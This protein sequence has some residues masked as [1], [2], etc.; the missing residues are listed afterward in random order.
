MIRDKEFFKQ[1]FEVKYST[2]LNG[3]PLFIDGCK[4]NVHAEEIVFFENQDYSK[5]FWVISTQVDTKE[6]G[7]VWPQ[8][9]SVEK[10]FEEEGQL[11]NILAY[12]T[13]KPQ[14]LVK[15]ITQVNTE[16]V[17]YRCAR[18]TDVISFGTSSILILSQKA[19]DIFNCFNLGNHSAIPIQ[20]KNN[21]LGSHL[22]YFYKF[23]NDL[24]E[25]IDFKE[26][27]FYTTIGTN[28]DW[29]SEF[30]IGSI[31]EL[32]KLREHYDNEFS[33]PGRSIDIKPKKI[34]IN[35]TCLSGL[36]ILV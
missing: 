28:I 6:T 22:Y 18:L 19:K 24:S 32:Q 8:I 17:L 33:L 7:K 13:S 20:L 16:F 11:F 25:K 30:Q 14:D 31:E 15:R 9:K 1:N 21:K 4:T 23:F 5:D 2:Y 12:K 26:S 3:K 29:D 36:D 35:Q 27:I 10:G 34:L